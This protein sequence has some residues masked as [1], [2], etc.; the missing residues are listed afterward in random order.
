MMDALIG[1]AIVGGVLALF[2]KF[3]RPNASLIAKVAHCA[4]GSFASLI[5]EG[6]W[7][8]HTR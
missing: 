1:I 2:W 5:I 6:D 3:I 7:N 8:A 4:P